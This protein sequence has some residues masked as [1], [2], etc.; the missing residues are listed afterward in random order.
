MC[1][2]N[3]CI[4]ELVEKPNDVN[5]TYEVC[6]ECNSVCKHK[7]YLSRELLEV[8]H[9]SLDCDYCG[10]H[11][12][13]EMHCD[14]CDYIANQRNDDEAD[15]MLEIIYN[16]DNQTSALFYLSN[17]EGQFFTCNALISAGLYDQALK[18]YLVS[19]INTELF[20][21]S[22]LKKTALLNELLDSV[23]SL[24]NDLG[25]AFFNSTK[26]TTAYLK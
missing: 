25:N 9:F 21:E 24:N 23:N 10:Y 12:C 5:I 13:D 8:H 7:S 4:T 18:I 19:D 15:S 6:P 3:G 17:I 1:N 14:N 16:V 20:L 22:S 2:V 26:Q 11:E